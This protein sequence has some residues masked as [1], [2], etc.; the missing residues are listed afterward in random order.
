AARAAEAPAAAV[1]PGAAVA[2]AP[3]AAAAAVV[4]VARAAGRAEGRRSGGGGDREPVDPA[5]LAEGVAM[6][7]R[8]LANPPNPPRWPM[9]LRQMKQLLRQAT[10]DFDERK[11][12]SIVELMR[13]CQRDGVLRVERDRQGGLRVFSTGAVTPGVSDHSA[14]A[15]PDDLP[16]DIGNRLRP[17]EQPAEPPARGKGRRVHKPL[18]PEFP[19][20]EP[21]AIVDEAADL[22]IPAGEPAAAPGEGDEAPA[23][24]AKRARKTAAKKAVK[25]ART[26]KTAK[27]ARKN[28][29]AKAAD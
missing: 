3:A 13:A 17:G 28:P 22:P 20:D 2:A 16:D 15:V 25:T 21:E 18:L 11:Y 5:V 12:G 23:P 7:K 27:T 4:S 29:K 10:P 9:Y 8:V 24:K 1:A 6:V 14:A 26:A 19:D